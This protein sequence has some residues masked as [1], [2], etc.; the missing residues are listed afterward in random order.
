LSP[1]TV[2]RLEKELAALESSDSTQMVVLTVP[3][4]EGETIEGICHQDGPAV[5]ASAGRA[6]TTRASV[7]SKGERSVRIEVGRGLEGSL[8]DALTGR[9]IDHVIVP[10]FKKGDF[11]AGVEKGVG[12]MMAAARGEYQGTGKQ[13]GGAT[14]GEGTE[15]IFA[16][17]LI[18]CLVVMSVLRFLPA[19]VRA[20]IGGAGMLALGLLYRRAYGLVGPHGRAR[21]GAGNCRGRSSFAP[22]GAAA[23]GFSAEEAVFFGRPAASPEAADHSAAAARPENW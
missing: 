18:A 22:A 16:F 14:D 5:G 4:L 15:G 23:E 3:S 8:T 6:R 17:G 10:V 7:V 1:N 13:P 12:A 11:N 9:I 21:G 19:F 20:G 2:Q